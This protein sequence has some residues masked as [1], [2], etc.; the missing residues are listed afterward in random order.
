MQNVIVWRDGKVTADGQLLTHV[1][2][3]DVP[4]F[5]PAHDA[6]LP[7]VTFD[8]VGTLTYSDHAYAKTPQPLHPDTQRVKAITHKIEDLF[9]EGKI[10]VEIKNDLLSA[11]L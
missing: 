8:V 1:V 5:K 4:T 9:S 7:R 2:D 3:I 6:I 10:K 11:L